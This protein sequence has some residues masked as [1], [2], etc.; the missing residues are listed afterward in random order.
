MVDKKDVDMRIPNWM[1]S[2]DIREDIILSYEWC[3]HR[4]SY[5]PARENGL[6]CI[7]SGQEFWVEC[8]R[9]SAADKPNT[10]VSVVEGYR[11]WP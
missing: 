10:V 1:C 3:Q 2:A 8:V 4:G 6:L 9:V 7:K 11:L 5:V